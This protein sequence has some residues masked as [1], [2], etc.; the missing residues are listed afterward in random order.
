MRHTSEW[1]ALQNLHLLPWM[2]YADKS[3]QG[4]DDS[5]SF[6]Q[7]IDWHRTARLLQ[8][9]WQTPWLSQNSGCSNSRQLR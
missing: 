8:P 7:T 5:A 1:A 3:E 6:Q 9:G 2:K 4:H